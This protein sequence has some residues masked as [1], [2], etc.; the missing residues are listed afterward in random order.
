MENASNPASKIT[1]LRKKIFAANL[2]GNISAAVN[3]AAALSISAFIVVRSFVQHDRS[4][5]LVV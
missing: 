3:C 1:I 2:H 4:P 5:L